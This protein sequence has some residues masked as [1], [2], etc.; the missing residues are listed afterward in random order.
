MNWARP[1][2]F[3]S[4]TLRKKNKKMS[5]DDPA[6]TP[7]EAMRR[8][9]SGDVTCRSLVPLEG[10]CSPY[11]YSNL[12]SCLLE[13]PDSLRYIF[14]S[15]NKLT[16]RNCIKLARYV[17]RSSVVRT[18]DISK[19]RIGFKTYTAIAK[20]LRVN[21]S[22]RELHAPTRGTTIR[23][24]I[25]CLFIEALRFNPTRPQNSV[26]NLFGNVFER[27]SDAAQKLG[28]PSMLSQLD[29]AEEK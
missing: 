25:E 19:N 9:K 6:H 28:P 3:F 14:V 20:A 15:N 21:T 24:K 22:L 11:E 2:C 13:H 10:T 26:W 18:I 4:S 29:F 1:P 5:F 27:L 17:E 16:D 12:F 23:A 7:M 8:I